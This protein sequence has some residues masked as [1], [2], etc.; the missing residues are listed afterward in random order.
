[1]V[2]P[3]TA[4]H[5]FVM[6]RKT[7]QAVFQSGSK[8]CTDIPMRLRTQ[9]PIV[10]TVYVCDILKGDM[11]VTCI[12]ILL[13]LLLILIHSHDTMTGRGSWFYGCNFG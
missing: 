7:S 10:M 8:I 3:N 6:Q 5:T 1:M 11:Y 2:I 9:N 12:A 4:K 13:H